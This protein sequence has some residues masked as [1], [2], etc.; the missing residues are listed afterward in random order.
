MKGPHIIVESPFENS[1]SEVLS[2]EFWGFLLFILVETIIEKAL[3]VHLIELFQKNLRISI[4]NSEQV[5]KQIEN[6]RVLVMLIKVD[7]DSR[8][9]LFDHHIQS[10][11]IVPTAQVKLLFSGREQ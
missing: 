5:L 11:V 3:L 8:E 9:K 4:V 10:K 1:I 2:T 7:L 6:V